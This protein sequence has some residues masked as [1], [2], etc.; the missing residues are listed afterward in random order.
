MRVLIVGGGGREHAMVRALRTSERDD[1]SILA[2]PGNPGMADLAACHRVPA[3][4]IAGLV[5]LAKA[6]LKENASK[7]TSHAIQIALGGFV[8]YAGIIVLLIGIGHLLGALFIRMGMSENLAEWLAPAVVG[9]AG[10]PAEAARLGRAVGG[11]ADVVA[12]PTGG[13]DPRRAVARHQGGILA[14][15]ADADVGAVASGEHVEVVLVEVFAQPP[16]DLGEVFGAHHVGQGEVAVDDARRLVLVKLVHTAVWAVVAGSIF[17]LYPAI[18]WGELK[19]FDNAHPFSIGDT[20][21]LLDRAKGKG[22]AGWGF[23]EQRLPDL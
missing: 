4:D 18:A 11:G 17:A 21:R 1:L 7:L 22:L 19:G 13:L 15:R 3:D 16:V 12:A 8:A 10:I 6:E 20:K 2:A 9:L 14:V 23:A 5:A